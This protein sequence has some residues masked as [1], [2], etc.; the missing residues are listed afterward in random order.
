MVLKLLDGAFNSNSQIKYQ[1][2]N[3]LLVLN[4]IL[5]VVAVVEFSASETLLFLSYCVL[6][7]LTQAG[8]LE[9]L[10]YSL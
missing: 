6:V 9:V 3:I 10:R 8:K 7:L 1:F 2:I 5:L 4:L